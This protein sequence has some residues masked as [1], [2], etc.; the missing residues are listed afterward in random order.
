MQS[1]SIFRKVV[2]DMNRLAGKQRKR[3]TLDK[4]IILA[5]EYHIGQTDKIEEPYILHPI[6]VMLQMK[7]ESA[8][9][10]AVLHDI[11][12]DTE[13]SADNLLFLGY[14]DKVVDAVVA[15]TKQ[16]GEKYLDYLGRV[17]ANPIARK[18]K[19]ADIKDNLSEDRIKK[20]LPSVRAR[21]WHKYQ[22]ALS[23]LKG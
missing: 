21:L 4:A 7:T 17:N 15:I 18:V 5:A 10:V 14:P 6:R 12:E 8:R 13:M 19:I 3:P 1:N 16:P 20:L 2:T 9:I 11:I 22:Q 23:F